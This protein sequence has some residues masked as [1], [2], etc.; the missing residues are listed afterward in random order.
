MGSNGVDQG[1]DSE[2]VRNALLKDLKLG[3]TGCTHW[4]QSENRKESEM[5]K[6]FDWSN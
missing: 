4:R 6:D 3:E 5:T 1:G 2:R